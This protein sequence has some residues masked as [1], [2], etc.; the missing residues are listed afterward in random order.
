MLASDAL[1]NWQSLRLSEALIY[2]LAKLKSSMNLPRNEILTD[3]DC[4]LGDSSDLD[5]YHY[6]Q[7]TQKPAG[8]RNLLVEGM[9]ASWGKEASANQV[10]Q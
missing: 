8:A 2:K 5:R 9:Q 7:N 6:S 4:D 10:H 1:C 3:C